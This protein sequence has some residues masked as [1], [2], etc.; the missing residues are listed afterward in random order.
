MRRFNFAVSAGLPVSGGI[1]R[2]FLP[3]ATERELHLTAFCVVGQ[4][5]LYRFHR[6]IGKLLVGDEEYSSYTVEEIAEH[7]ARLC[8]HG[9]L[10]R[11]KEPT[12]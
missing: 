11:G 5:L 1:L 10:G 6:P 2:R 12:P 7:I 3:D 8:I 9:L 4:C